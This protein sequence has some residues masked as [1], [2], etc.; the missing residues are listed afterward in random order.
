[1]FRHKSFIRL[2]LVYN[3][4]LFKDKTVVKPRTSERR[5]MVGGAGFLRPKVKFNTIKDKLINRIVI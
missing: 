4:I 1:M 5:K 2:G 3:V